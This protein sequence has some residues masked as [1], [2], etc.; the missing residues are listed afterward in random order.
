MSSSWPRHTVPLVFSF[1]LPS[2]KAFSFPPPKKPLSA[3]VFCATPPPFTANWSRAAFF[4]LSP[5]FSGKRTV[6]HPP[7]YLAKLNMAV[8]PSPFLPLFKKQNSLFPPVQGYASPQV[9]F[10]PFSLPFVKSKVGTRP[11]PCFSLPRET[12]SFSLFFPLKRK[13]PFP[14][15]ILRRLFVISEPPSLLFALVERK[16][17]SSSKIASPHLFGVIPKFPPLSP[18]PPF[19]FKV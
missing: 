6:L 8:V 11:K 1:F 14:L 3:C 5:S 19:A 18:F 2:I 16:V 13:P 9:T 10:L 15:C 4:F 7:C 17:F 12:S